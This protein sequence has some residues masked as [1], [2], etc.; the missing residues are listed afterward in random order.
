MTNLREKIGS[1][2]RRRTYFR[3]KGHHLWCVLFS[4]D[5]LLDRALRLDTCWI[6]M[7]VVGKIVSTLCHE[8]ESI[9][10]LILSDIK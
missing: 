4:G 1:G 10:N 6:Q 5:Y 9:K 2:R 7:S 3:V 8:I